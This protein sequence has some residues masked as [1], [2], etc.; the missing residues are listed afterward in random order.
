[1]PE[2]T[3]EE[4]AIAILKWVFWEIENRSI[5][6]VKA[7]I[8]ASI[9]ALERRE[10]SKGSAE[11]VAE[12]ITKVYGNSHKDRVLQ[13]TAIIQDYG[14][15]LTEKVR[16][17]LSDLLR[18]I[19]AWNANPHMPRELKDQ[20]ENSLIIEDARASLPT[21]SSKEVKG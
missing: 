8:G 12:K 7:K 20:I 1:M 16:E 4:S 11:E 3:K 14:D 15:R 19:D 21:E 2:I 5:Q 10:Q 17:K 13:I 18:L 9:E 6:E